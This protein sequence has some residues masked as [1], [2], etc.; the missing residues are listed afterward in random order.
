M[1]W[2]SRKFLDLRAHA[3]CGAFHPTQPLFAAAIGSTIIGT[4]LCIP[5]RTFKYLPI[6]LEHL[7]QRLCLHRESPDQRV[8]TFQSIQKLQWGYACV[9]EE[10]GSFNTES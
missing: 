3:Q 7:T 10:S 6:T 1:E 4:Y 2:V 5:F 9:A 8:Y